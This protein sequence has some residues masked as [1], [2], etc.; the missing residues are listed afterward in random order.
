MAGK[1]LCY[2]SV[3]KS[4][5]SFIKA[6]D[7]TLHYLGCVLH[8]LGQLS[9]SVETFWPQEEPEK[10]K[11]ENK[12]PVVYICSCVMCHCQPF[13]K[14]KV[15]VSSFLRIVKHKA[16]AKTRTYCSRNMVICG[17]EGLLSI[18]LA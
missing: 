9:H 4:A 13:V 14:N 17:I 18:V 16:I 2:L 6:H 7:I 11:I 5:R 8:L 15:I 1:S 12:F 3:R 10:F